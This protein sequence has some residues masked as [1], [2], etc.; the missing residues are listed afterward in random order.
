MVDALDDGS[1]D[2][3][4]VVRCPSPF[5]FSPFLC[6]IREF[7]ALFWGMPSFSGS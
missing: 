7:L 2:D 6:F 1:V 5:W 4:L 3:G